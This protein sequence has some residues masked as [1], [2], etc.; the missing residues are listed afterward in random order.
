MTK[1]ADLTKKDDTSVTPG[2]LVLRSEVADQKN[3]AANESISVFAQGQREKTVGKLDEFEGNTGMKLDT[4]KPGES[5]TPRLQ[6]FIASN[7][8]MS[9]V[10]YLSDLKDT[11][12]G[13]VKNVKNVKRAIAAAQRIQEK[14]ARR[15][16]MT[17]AEAGAY[18]LQI[19]VEDLDTVERFFTELI[20]RIPEASQALEQALK[21]SLSR[22]A[23]AE[24][25][26]DE[27]GDDEDFGPVFKGFLEEKVFGED[28]FNF[29][30]S[31]YLN[32]EADAHIQTF[33]TRMA[34]EFM[35]Y[36][37]GKMQTVQKNIAVAILVNTLRG[38][39]QKT[40]DLTDLSLRGALGTLLKEGSD[41]LELFKISPSKY[42]EKAIDKN[43]TKRGA[44]IARVEMTFDD[45]VPYSYN[46]QQVTPTEKTRIDEMAGKAKTVSVFHM[47]NMRRMFEELT[48][49][50]KVT[51]TVR[52]GEEDFPIEIQGLSGP[53][54]VLLGEGATKLGLPVNE[55]CLL[56][57]KV[58]DVKLQKVRT[59]ERPMKVVRH[60]QVVALLAALSPDAK[61]VVTPT[62]AK[63]PANVTDETKGEVKALI[64]APKTDGISEEIPEIVDGASDEVEL[65]DEA[66][67]PA[68]AVD[69]QAAIEAEVAGLSEEDKV[70]I[71]S[72]VSLAAEAEKDEARRDC[73]QEF[74]VSVEAIDRVVAEA[75][76][77]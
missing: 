73:A 8:A 54:V 35:Q 30:H 33:L 38:L 13:R 47:N 34:T 12:V 42:M 57:E 5:I 56:G 59:T 7:G 63:T 60:E 52:V 24:I 21:G 17:E 61:I 74:G 55:A 16:N 53:G 25:V 76:Q 69:A 19:N 27:L 40:T 49:A 11:A 43:G 2:S 10:G 22:Y 44:D 48:S 62:P 6:R 68:E 1:D 15:A 32:G 14:V 66:E 3:T 36:A 65:I 18:K 31:P 4:V 75:E 51:G 58:G 26:K 37:E 41:E 72:Y 23:A 71:R 45:D 28:L 64:E 20:G 29:L 50:S 67:A 77:K 70:N 9:L 39:C 46:P